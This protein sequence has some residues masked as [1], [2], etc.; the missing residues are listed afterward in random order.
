MA[1]MKRLPKDGKPLCKCCL[2]F[3]IQIHAKIQCNIVLT[4]KV[5][6]LVLKPMLIW[7]CMDCLRLAPC[8]VETLNFQDLVMN[9]PWV[10]F[11]SG[12]SAATP[13]ELHVGKMNY[14]SIFPIH[15][16]CNGLS[17]FF[18]NDTKFSQYMTIQCK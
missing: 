14:G 9:V 12:V 6:I 18:Y 8:E 15:L 13:L 3:L 7:W 4:L 10:L 2:V 17:N 11:L 5:F 16:I 1:R